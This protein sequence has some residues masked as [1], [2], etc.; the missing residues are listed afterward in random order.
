MLASK[1]E[2]QLKNLGLNSYEVKLWAALLSHGVSTAG[3]L[4]DIANVPRSRSYDV[5][6]S[7]KSKGFVS[8][9]IGKPLKY[10]AINP[11]KVVETV[12]QKIQL[13]ANNE[14]KE[15]INLKNS[16]L[17]NELVLLHGQ[18]ADLTGSTEMTGCLQGKSNIYNHLEEMIRN[19]SKSVLISATQNEFVEMNSRLRNVFE[20]LK[21]KGVKVKMLTQVND[22]TKKYVNELK[23]LAEIKH[24][25]NK[26]R[27]CIVD[28]KEMVFMVLD[29]T[30]IHPSYD[31]AIWVNSPLA[32]DFER[33]YF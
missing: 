11:Q 31:V 3:E 19:A 8:V 16:G 6:E 1:I 17:V 9:K 26:S 29:E 33:K 23:N 10:E 27:F 24:T 18:G 5:L 21:S 25:N 2:K 12:K 14:I 7:L 30:Q 15:L 4:S 13:D 28:G 22:V 32:K 20:K